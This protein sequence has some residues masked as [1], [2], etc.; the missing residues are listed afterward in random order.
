MQMH[1]CTAGASCYDENFHSQSTFS[2]QVRARHLHLARRLRRQPAGPR[3]ERR[4]ALGELWDECAAHVRRRRGFGPPATRRCGFRRQPG[5]ALRALGRSRPAAARGQLPRRAR[6]PDEGAG[7][8]GERRLRA[9]R[10]AR[11]ERELSRLRRPARVARLA[12]VGH[13]RRA[14][15]LRGHRA[16]HPG[17]RCGTGTRRGAHRRDRAP[18]PGVQLPHR[19]TS[20]AL[21]APFP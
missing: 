15:G 18:R 20:R 16:P 1:Y 12:A 13:D 7:V 8:A 6:R 19:A 9:L 2:D 5:D 10:A 14:R 21:P 17:G 4:L 3:A 11:S